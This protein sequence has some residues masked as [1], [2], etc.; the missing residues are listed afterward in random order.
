MDLYEAAKKIVR[1]VLHVGTL[2]IF[3]ETF[4]HYLGDTLI[5]YPILIPIFNLKT[6]LCRDGSKTCYEVITVILLLVLY[7]LPHLRT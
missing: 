7:M 1:D 5:A 3:Q 2:Y 4:C 6:E